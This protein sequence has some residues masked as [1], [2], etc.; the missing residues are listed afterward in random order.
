MSITSSMYT[1]AAG[2][3]S[4]S[5]AMGVI[6]DNI[7]N[8]NTVGFRSSRANFSDVL[9]GMLAGSHIGAG[10]MIG[11][12]QTMFAEGALLGT[13]NATDL[14]IRG[15]G[16]FVVSGTLD[17]ITS[18]YYTRA[19]QFQMDP[20][21]FM[22]T[23][24][25]LRLQGYGL[26]GQG[27]LMTTPG[28]LQLDTSALPPT[29]TTTAGLDANLDA[30]QAVDPTPFDILDPGATSDWSTSVTVYDSLGT[31]HQLTMFFKKT[32]DAPTQ[33]WDVHV[34]AAGADVDPAVAQEY[35]ELGVS[36]LDFD[37]A[38]ALTASSLASVNVPWAGAAAATIALDFGTPTSAG[39]SG[40]DGLTSYAG[41]SAATAIAQ[42]GSGTGELSEFSILPDGTIEARYSN[43]QSRALGQVVTARFVSN[44][45]LER[46]GDALFSATGDSREPVLGV[47]GTRG[48]GAVAAGSLEASNVD[49]AREFVTMIAVQRGFQSNSRTISTADEMLT[50]IVSLKR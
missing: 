5:D 45:G 16:F 14:A 28:D 17:G 13:G 39:G 7:A 30:G 31:P 37:T 41:A 35:T 4:H 26:D 11:S 18:D 8:V 34:A 6:S 19:G 2:L 15:D 38:G 36:T 9:G 1:G 50:D 43:G 40:V 48:H 33:Q 29:A 20:D 23:A 42:D 27:N 25:G 24:G 44:E 22:T 10:S 3:S 47:P 49:L 32:A 46:H 21:G 12:V